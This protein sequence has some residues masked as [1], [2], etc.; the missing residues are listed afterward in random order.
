MRDAHSVGQFDDFKQSSKHAVSLNLIC[1][2][3]M[4]YLVRIKETR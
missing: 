2:N 4:S 1:I 3:L